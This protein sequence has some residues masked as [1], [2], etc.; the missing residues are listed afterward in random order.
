MT[1]SAAKV[2]SLLARWLGRRADDASDLPRQRQ[3]TNTSAE[4]S[5]LFSL[6]DSRQ[7][8]VASYRSA[9]TEQ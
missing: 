4:P 6:G 5:P 2:R 8:L 3:D 9:E 7:E 1:A